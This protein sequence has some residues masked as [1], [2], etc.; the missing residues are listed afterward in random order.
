M[1]CLLAWSALAQP[2]KSATLEGIVFAAEPGKVFVPVEEAVE[3]LKWNLRQDDDGKVFELKGL[4]MRAGSLRSLT[5][6]TE[7]VDLE[8]LELAGAPVSAPDEQGRFR[9]GRLFRGFTVLVSAQRVEVSLAAQTLECWQ[10]GRLV[11]KTRISSGRRGSTPKGDFRAG[12][13][14]A[15]M[16][17]SSRYQNAPMPW[18]VQINGHVFIHG[19][20]SVPA[21]PASHGC[22]RLPLDEGNPAKFFFEWVLNGTPVRVR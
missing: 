16:H 19:F 13:Y 14:R 1:L 7:L 8:L 11:L 15:V 9:V 12:P 4:P 18:S 21:Y 22:I 5:D 17:R 3:E 10:G 2:L 20:T 6:G